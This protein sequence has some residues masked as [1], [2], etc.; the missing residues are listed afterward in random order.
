MLEFKNITKSYN[1]SKRK[2]IALDDISFKLPEKGLISIIGK[3]GSGKTTILNILSGIIKPTSGTYLI[4]NK[5]SSS[6]TNEDWD[7]IRSEY[8][9]YVFQDNN[10]INSLTV[11]ENLSILLLNHPNYDEKDIDKCLEKLDI[12]S[13]KNEI[14]SNLSGGE[15][16]RVALARALFK[17]SKVILADEV[18]ASL[19]EENS[20]NVFKT[21]K[22][23]SKE[24]LVIVVTH[25]TDLAMEYSDSYIKMNYGKIKETTIEEVKDN[26]NEL[27]IKSSNMPNKNINK[28]KNMVFRGFRWQSVFSIIFNTLAFVL[29]AISLHFI[30]FNPYR[31]AFECNK[32][33]N[34]YT[35]T[36]DVYDIDYKIPDDAFPGVDINECYQLPWPTAS[37][38]GNVIIDDSIPDNKLI[39]PRKR[40]EDLVKD[41]SASINGNVLDISGEKFQ[42]EVIDYNRNVNYKIEYMYNWIVRGNAKTIKRYSRFFTY[43]DLGKKDGKSIA[44]FRAP[45]FTD[46]DIRRGSKVISGNEVIVSYASSY[47]FDDDLDVGDTIIIGESEFVIK[48]LYDNLGDVYTNT[49]LGEAIY[50]SAEKYD[51]LIKNSEIHYGDKKS[52]DLKPD[53]LQEEKNIIDILNKYGF[54][55]KYRIYIYNDQLK[56]DYT[57]G[58]NM[59][60]LILTLGII[61][62]TLGVLL[63]FVFNKLNNKIIIKT[64]SYK[65]GNI[66][67]LGFRKKDIYKSFNYEYLING[68]IVLL[69]SAIIEI[70]VLLITNA[71]VKANFHSNYFYNIRINALWIISTFIVFYGIVLLLLNKTIKK[72]FKQSISELLSYE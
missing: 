59:Q 70:I 62:A 36:E 1:E 34:I 53:S 42:L 15:Q 25:D 3:S 19:D 30:L 71:I 39:M 47:I 11:Y 32:K 61:F 9:S 37:H 55:S 17:K 41:Y 68:L 23:V 12:L 27:K 65:M 5:D 24:V 40:C 50:L 44:G 57:I 16:E 18:T 63:F 43:V 52:F 51:E 72:M 46:N 14:V 6:L 66:N 31:Y 49:E 38:N 26:T 54:D 21:L 60:D 48:G 56:A 33:A 69:A 7:N 45:N 10:L 64:H 28:F 2:N 8:F 67:F 20:I 4:D 29:I 13:L 35:M 22:E 58:K